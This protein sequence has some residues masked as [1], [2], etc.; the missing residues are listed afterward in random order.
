MASPGPSAKSI[1]AEPSTPTHAL[2]PPSQ[3]T[4]SPDLDSSPNSLGSSRPQSQH[5]SST[6]ISDRSSDIE[7][8]QIP[9]SGPEVQRMHSG[10]Y[11]LQSHFR[12]AQ[13]DQ[14][15]HNNLLYIHRVL[16]PYPM[17]KASTKVSR[18]L[19]KPA[20]EIGFPLI[21]CLKTLKH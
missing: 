3:S 10:S 17:P 15:L 11:L 21:H 8:A 5:S 12:R 6:S 7:L 14:T 1:I 18:K 16:H 20:M 19:N 4:S 9:K 2:T 13:Q